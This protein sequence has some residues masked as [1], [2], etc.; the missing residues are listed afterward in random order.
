MKNINHNTENTINLA[1]PEWVNDF[2]SLPHDF[3]TIEK[4]MDFAIELSRKNIENNTGGPFGAAIF[5][6]DT[7]ELISAGVNV[8]VPQNACIAHA[9][10]MAIAFAQKKLK[11]FSLANI[12]NCQYE[13]VTSAEPCSMCFGSTLW[14]GIK[15]CTY[16]ATAEDVIAIGFDEGDKPENWIKSLTSRGIACT[17]EI[18]RDKAKEALNFYASKSGKIYNGNSATSVG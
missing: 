3:S 4:R 7:H 18:Q 10:M 9:E 5:D 1:L 12:E 2:C 15:S 8:V 11:T 17:G 6:I 13:L 14:S 16:G